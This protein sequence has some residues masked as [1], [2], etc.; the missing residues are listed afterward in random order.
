MLVFCLVIASI[1]HAGVQPR[2]YVGGY[3]GYNDVTGN[4]V[5]YSS[6]ENYAKYMCAHTYTD[7]LPEQFNGQMAYLSAPSASNPFPQFYW[8]CTAQSPWVD[9]T[10]H[11]PSIPGGYWCLDS[12][13]ELDTTTPPNCDI[14][15]DKPP[16]L[17]C[18]KPA[19][20]FGDPIDMSA[21]ETTLQEQD[22][23]SAHGLA[24]TRYYSSNKLL[25]NGDGMR[26]GW[27]HNYSKRLTGTK[28]VNPT[29]SVPTYYS[30]TQRGWGPSYV[31]S[32]PVVSGVTQDYAYL[33]RPDGHSYYFTSPDGGVSW[34]SDSDVNY[35][36]LTQSDGSGNILQWQLITPE[37]D[38]E[39]YDPAGRLIAIQFRSGRSQTLTYSD[40]STPTQ[41]APQPGLLLQV[42]DNFGAVLHFQYDSMSRLV[43]MTDAAGQLYIYA[44]DAND[45]LASVTYPNGLK[46]QYLYA[47]STYD[48]VAGQSAYNH[49]LTGV[50]D[51]ISSGNFVRYTTITYDSSGNPTSTQLP[52]GVNK[53]SFNYSSNVVTDPLGTQRTYNYA[54]INGLSLPSSVSAPAGAGCS[55]ATSY[56][57]YESNNGNPTSRIDFN[58]N[59][60]TYSYDLARNL[61][62]RRVEAAYTSQSRTISTEWHS[63]Y[64]LP[65]KVAEPLKLTTYTYDSAGNLLTKTEQATTDTAGTA[66]FNATPTGSPRT[67]SYTYNSVG[68]LLTATDPLNHAT[69]Y[70]YDSQGNL[71]SLTN[72]AGQTM[73]LANYDANGRV[74]RITDPNGVI[75]DLSYTVRG[76]LSSKTVTAPGV[77]EVTS[78][79]YD[80]IGELKQVTLPDGTTVNYTYDEA[81]RLTDIT[82]SLGNTAHYTL[83]AMGNRTGEQVKDPSGTLAR[84]ITRVYDA[85]NRLQTI[86]GGL[87]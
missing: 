50:S 81:R 48:Q 80:G 52:N 32:Q 56:T 63:Q 7:G 35:K 58:G 71:T 49:L 22:Y 66:L 36:L 77:S 8:Y 23:A 87:Q 74:G 34:A 11:G 45:N 73:T 21:K 39:I 46:R 12:K 84:Q 64:R 61:E 57:Y 13:N 26:Q 69:S 67:W 86:T 30:W 70:A 79:A 19:N 10:Q 60:T 83:D 78:Y 28:V 37:Y 40:A 44:Y 1:A 4:V 75:T 20:S 27:R 41:I 5:I 59:T 51:E 31:A 6:A 42:S 38:T 15:T 65:V 2:P 76:W 14:E 55:A 18:G 3:N 17:S 43:Q 72:A 24:F 29:Y 85:L 53:Y 82:D 68:Q 25:Q 33:T 9:N 16:L 47:E 62:T 54:N